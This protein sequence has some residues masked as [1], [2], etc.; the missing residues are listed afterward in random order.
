MTLS[1]VKKLI[2]TS[3]DLDTIRKKMDQAPKQHNKK[4]IQKAMKKPSKGIGRFTKKITETLL[5]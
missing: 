3:P 1:I 4:H 2:M 5:H